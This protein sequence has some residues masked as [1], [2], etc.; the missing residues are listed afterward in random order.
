MPRSMCAAVEVGACSITLSSK[1]MARSYCCSSS[2][3][4][5]E[6]SAARTASVT[7]TCC[8]IVTLSASR[9]TSM[10]AAAGGGGGCFVRVDPAVT[11]RRA[12]GSHPRTR[13]RA[14][15]GIARQIAF[16]D[17]ALLRIGIFHRSL[18]HRHRCR[19]RCLF[20]LAW[21]RAGVAR[22]RLRRLLGLAWR[23]AG[24]A[25]R[26]GRDRRYRRSVHVTVNG[27]DEAAA[28]FVLRVAARHHLGEPAE[29]LLRPRIEDAG[30]QQF[31][32]LLVYLDGFLLERKRCLFEVL[33]ELLQVRALHVGR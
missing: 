33:L 18:V 8:V 29:A 21:R 27:A 31:H 32:V 20:R 11:P 16:S 30:V 14:S 26:R 9:T 5:A 17:R 4:T 24:V 13:N 12:V 3:C 15:H 25:W 6:S 2:I 1:A 7:G 23:R 19:V 28:H 10:S 22:C